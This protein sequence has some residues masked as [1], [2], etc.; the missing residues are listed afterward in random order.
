MAEDTAKTEELLIERTGRRSYLGL[1]VS[2]KGD[3]TI[4]VNVTTKKKHPLYQ[5]YVRQDKKLH[6]HD[7][8][9]VAGEGDTVEIQEVTRK[10]SK[11]KRYELVRIVERAK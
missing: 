8:N 1:V 9:N 4:V 7:V 11:L 5:K 3:K 10:L 6:A 2:N